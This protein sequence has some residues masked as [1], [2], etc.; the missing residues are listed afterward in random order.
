[1]T[2]LAYFQRSM[3]TK[4]KGKCAFC[5]TA[6]VP[7]VDYAA[8]NGKWIAVCATHAN[9]DLTAQISA[10]VLSLNDQAA[11]L[12]EAESA[13]LAARIPSTLPAVFDGTASYTEAVSVV[14]T[15]LALQTTVHALAPAPVRAN[16]YA[17]TC[18]TCKGRVAEGAGRIQRDASTGKWLTF[19][20]DGQCP[21][22]APTV[23]TP[24]VPAG[25]YAVTLDG[26][27]KFYKVDHGA[28]GGKWEGCTFVSVQASDDFH[29]IRN[30]ASRTAI[31]DAIAADVA[32]AAGA[33]GQHFKRCG[34]C[35]HGLTRLYSRSMGYGP[36]CAD[37][38]GLP[39]DHAAYAASAKAE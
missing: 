12:P 26:V 24:T 3:V 7:G 16:S 10:L 19:H 1:M 29:P 6:T 30:R 2:N 28:A 22:V 34:F 39:F 14:L 9:A 15:L 20:L 21:T 18:Q 33:Y 25:R 31:L 5:G 38:L 37:N 27:L 11:S 35:M 32:G 13:L 17:G 23:A 36:D 4:C 8:L